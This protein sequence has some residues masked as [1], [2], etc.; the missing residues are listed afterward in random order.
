MV[1]NFK[2][3]QNTRLFD[4]F[5][6]GPLM[7]WAGMGMPMGII[8]RTVLVV[9]GIMTTFFNGAN[10]VSEGRQQS[11]SGLGGSRYRHR[12]NRTHIRGIYKSGSFE[13]IPTESLYPLR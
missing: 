5:V 9:S 2:Q 6:L 1:T 11:L 3:T 8:L 7:I 10:Y 12:P 13:R 4:V